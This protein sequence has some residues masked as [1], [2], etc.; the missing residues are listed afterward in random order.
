MANEISD[1]KGDTTKIAQQLIGKFGFS[2]EERERLDQ[3]EMSIGIVANLD[4]NSRGY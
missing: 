1:L 3:I 2:L 4:H